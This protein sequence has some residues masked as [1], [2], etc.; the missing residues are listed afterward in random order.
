MITIPTK[1]D[2]QEAYNRGPTQVQ[3]YITS[4]ELNEVFEQIREAHKL[5]FD[6]ADKLTDALVSVFFELRSASEFPEL[7]REA[8][9]QNSDKYDAVL[10]DVNEKIFKV[11]RQ[12]LAG[13]DTAPSSAAPPA[14]SGTPATP[15][16]KPTPQEPPQEPPI[17]PAAPPSAP[18]TPEKTRPSEEPAAVPP[19]PAA[20]LEKK[21]NEKPEQ[22]SVDAFDDDAEKK[23]PLQGAPYR[24]GVD[25]Y[26]EPLE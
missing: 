4:N 22:V 7:L 12:K 2:I 20:A 17:V 9:E 15:V 3:S 11:F 14:P 13:K 10:K 5:H 26:R 21:T 16:P 23:S 1:Q 8:L 6:E 24:S 25:P 19:A 18:V